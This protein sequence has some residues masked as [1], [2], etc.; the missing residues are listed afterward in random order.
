MRSEMKLSKFGNLLIAL[1]FIAAFFDCIENIALIKLLL[2]DLEQVWSSIAYYFA[3]TPISGFEIK[4]R[5]SRV[6]SRPQSLIIN[7]TCVIN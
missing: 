6:P 1:I 2:G 5:A 7:D 4:R 3:K